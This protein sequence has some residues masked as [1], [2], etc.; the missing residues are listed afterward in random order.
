ML[1][2][3]CKYGLRAIF[4]LA[5]PENQSLVLGIRKISDDL[6]IP[7]PYLS[8]ILQLLSKSRILKSNKGP[9]GGFS[10]GRKPSEIKLIDVVRL[11]DGTSFFD[12]CVIGVRNCCDNK[13]IAPCILHE[14]Y[15]II[16]QNLLILFNETTVENVISED[17]DINYFT[18][19]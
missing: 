3:S 12:N 10:I 9:G 6:N 8:K 7:A 19:Y 1:S 11:I 15:Q 17:I 18:S 5:L 13:K 4:Y 2:T 16:R 14:R